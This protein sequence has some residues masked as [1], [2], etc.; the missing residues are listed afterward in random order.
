MNAPLIS[1]DALTG[2]AVKPLDAIRA[3]RA[4][5]DNSTRDDLY[6]PAYAD[7]RYLLGLV[8]ELGKQ[9]HEATALMPLGTKKR[10]Q[11]LSSALHVLTKA[12]L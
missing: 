5:V 12:A 3:I 2:P 6:A 7:R 9:L 11:W 10:A 1:G 8:D 4:R